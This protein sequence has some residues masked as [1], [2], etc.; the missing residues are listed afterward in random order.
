MAIRHSHVI[1]YGEN[2]IVP[3]SGS[4]N[5]ALITGHQ[6]ADA[7]YALKNRGFGVEVGLEIGLQ[8]KCF[9]KFR[10]SRHIKDSIESHTVQKN[11]EDDGDGF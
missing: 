10:N 8:N 1:K 2:K 11:I 9:K 4:K 3:T 5:C 6:D 7:L